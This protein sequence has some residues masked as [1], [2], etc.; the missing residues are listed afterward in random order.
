M[1]GFSLNPSPPIALLMTAGK[2]GRSLHVVADD[3]R[4]MTSQESVNP[5]QMSSLLC[6]LTKK[7]IF[8]VSSI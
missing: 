7:I 5:P 1:T 2:F 6:S 3:S 8:K 4:L